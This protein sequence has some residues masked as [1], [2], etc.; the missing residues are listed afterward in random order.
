MLLRY[1]VA[2]FQ[3]IRDYQEISLV[4][5]SLKDKIGHLCEVKG[6]KNKILPTVAIYGANASGKTNIL[7]ALSFMVRGILHSHTEGP[8]EGG[9]KRHFFKLD[10][11]YE[12]MPSK[13]DC[14]FICNKIRYHFGYT[15]DNE[16][17]LEEWLYAYPLGTKQVWYYRKSGSPIIFGKFLKGKNKIIESMTRSNSLFISVAAQNNN[18]QLLEVYKYFKENFIFSFDNFGPFKSVSKFLTSDITRDFMMSFLKHADVGIVSARVEEV[19]VPENIKEINKKLKDL[20]EKIKN[21]RLDTNEESKKVQFSH[22]GVYGQEV[23]F[24]FSSESRGTVALTKMLGPIIVALSR[25]MTIVIDELDTSMHSLMSIK[26]I[27][28]FNKYKSNIN[29]AQ[30]IFSTHDTS[31]LS[32]K[33]LRRDEIWFT[34]KNLEGATEII[35]LAEIKTRHTDNFE[36]GYLQGRYGGIPFLTNLDDIFEC[37]EGV[38]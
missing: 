37:D 20:L 19:D 32:N 11:R 24:D 10:P 2:N 21:V 25:G 6:F 5:S 30:I 27:E 17:I 7:K 4:A 35:S 9:I 29:C 22:K 26:L 12:T 38:R 8:V 36:E 16:K 15:L 31:L 18:D 13:F 34:E 3:S 1:G 28:L 14:D 33:V 23:Y